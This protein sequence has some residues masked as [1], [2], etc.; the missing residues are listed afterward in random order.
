MTHS[1]A[2]ATNECFPR[3]RSTGKGRAVREQQESR[4]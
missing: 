1:A 4:R 2:Y 3:S